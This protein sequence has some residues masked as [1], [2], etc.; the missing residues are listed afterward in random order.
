MLKY[1][2]LALVGLH[3]A[4]GS[5]VEFV[6]LIMLYTLA[7]YLI[8]F[9]IDRVER[10]VLL[11]TEYKKIG[12]ES[13]ER[14]SLL[15]QL[16]G[17]QELSL[18]KLVEELYSRIAPLFYGKDLETLSKMKLREVIVYNV[19]AGKALFHY[20]FSYVVWGVRS[21]TSIR[22]WRFKKPP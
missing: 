14:D 16:A 13:A 9:P 15:T 11:D 4:Q 22:E 10:F 20:S 7:Q 3:S 18:D 21:R 19:K 5:S 2:C 6:K 12:K 1:R 17:F 8:K